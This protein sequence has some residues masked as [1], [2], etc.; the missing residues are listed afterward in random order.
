M[1]TSEHQMEL[2][3]LM[4]HAAHEY[5]EQ[6]EGTKGAM[7]LRN[8][9]PNP[10]SYHELLQEDSE[11]IDWETFVQILEMDGPDEDDD[12]QFSRGIVSNFFQQYQ[13]SIIAEAKDLL[14]VNVSSH[15]IF[16][17]LQRS[18]WR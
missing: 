18:G 13:D 4:D 11:S 8:L 1:K 14:Y 7:R 6:T 9:V 17:T 15:L 10:Q 2:L 12:H 3:A 16:C 5:G